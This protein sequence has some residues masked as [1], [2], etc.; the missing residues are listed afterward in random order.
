MPKLT[1]LVAYQDDA[2]NRV[3]YEG[4][5]LP[6][7]SIS[8]EFRGKNNTLRVAP[9]AKIVDLA[10]DFSGDDGTVDVGTTSKSRAG[11]RFSAR[12]G[13][14]SSFV[15]GENVGFENRAFVRASEGAE[16]IIGEDCMLAA[17]I[18][19]RADDTHAIYDV[20]TGKRA[21]PSRSIHIGEHVWLGKN[22]VVMGG[23][24]IGNGAV[25]GFRSVVTRSI[26]NN[27]VAAG[28]PAR[29]V[30]RDVAWER[31][32]LSFRKP[33]V[34]GLSPDETKS[35]QWWNLTDDIFDETEK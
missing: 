24:T 10:I 6:K 3:I 18:E 28:V 8:I 22:A 31:P 17:N 34:D 19:L 14:E 1:A 30:R 21:N 11:I 23:V 4:A 20:R 33:G 26:P 35:E 5:A 9:G 16:V 29:V 25:V 32:V 13:H 27:C 12:L 7:A 2:G 15:V